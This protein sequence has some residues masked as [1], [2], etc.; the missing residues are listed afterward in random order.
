MCT[1]WLPG[2][3][4][5]P[6]FLHSKVRE[7]MHFFSSSKNDLSRKS[8]FSLSTVEI[9]GGNGEE[10]SLTSLIKGSLTCIFGRYQLWWTMSRRTWSIWEPNAAARY[11]SE[12]LRE[13]EKLCIHLWSA[14]QKTSLHL[15]LLT[16]FF[17]KIFSLSLSQPLSCLASVLYSTMMPQSLRP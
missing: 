17:S 4:K 8:T 2:G 1:L 9:G 5:L 6:S 10:G 11:G 14:S 3:D 15:L 12:V 7:I 13:E 16:L